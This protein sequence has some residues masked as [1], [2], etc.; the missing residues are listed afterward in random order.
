MKL[1]IKFRAKNIRNDVIINKQ[2]SVV[3]LNEIIAKLTK[4]LEILRRYCASLERELQSMKGSG[5]DM[6]NFK[7][8][9]RTIFI[10]S[11]LIY[12]SCMMNLVKSLH[13]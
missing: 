10:F 13:H 5:F 7:K 2:S 4:E 6:K 11:E 12:Y 3:D 1:K 9:V 8:K